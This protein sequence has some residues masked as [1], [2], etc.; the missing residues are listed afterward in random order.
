[1]A[2][3]VLLFSSVAL[4]IPLDRAVKKHL[5]GNALLAKAPT[6]FIAHSQ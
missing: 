5:Q 1:M 4:T 2:W 6:D 3:P